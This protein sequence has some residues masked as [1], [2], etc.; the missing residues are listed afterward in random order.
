METEK[1]NSNTPK[2]V[3]ITGFGPLTA[4]GAAKL[5]YETIAARPDGSKTNASPRKKRKQKKIQGQ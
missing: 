5:E 1:Q 3:P 4:V 2:R